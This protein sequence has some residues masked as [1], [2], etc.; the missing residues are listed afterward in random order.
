VIC[1][2]HKN[3]YIAQPT[4]RK[5]EEL[6]NRLLLSALTYITEATLPQFPD[7]ISVNISL[8]FKR[9]KKILP[10]ELGDEWIRA[11]E[12]TTRVRANYVRQLRRRR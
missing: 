4:G 8:I 12:A 3:K 7:K 6:Q 9:A 5:K 1:R 10:D 2:K 11:D